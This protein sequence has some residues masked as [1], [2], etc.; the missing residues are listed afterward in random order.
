VFHACLLHITRN[1]YSS[2]QEGAN[3]FL[4]WEV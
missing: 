4:D 1:L 3:V 2:Q